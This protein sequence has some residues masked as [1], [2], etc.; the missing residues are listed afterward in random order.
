MTRRATLFAFMCGCGLAVGGCA[1]LNHKP[2]ADAAATAPSATSANP[3]PAATTANPAINADTATPIPD[4]DDTSPLIQWED[5]TIAP[6][7]I[8]YANLW[9]YLGK[10]FSLSAAGGD[11]RVQGELNWFAGHGTYLQRT[12]NR[13][14]PYLY[15]IVQQVQARKIPLD[16]ALLPVVE[17]AF[18]PFAYSNG[19]AAGLWQFIPGT[20]R[21]WD[22]KQDWW[23]DGRRDIVASTNAALDYLQ[24]LHNQFNN[25][26]LLALA[27]YNSGGGTVSRAIQRNLRRGLPTDF[28]HLDLPAETRAYVPRLLAICQLIATSGH[29][30]VDLPAIPNI[31]YLAVVD[32]GGQ[33]DLATAAK[34]A[35][36]T[37]EQ[38]YLL[39][40][41][42][43][44]WATDPQG[45]YSLLVP[46]DK[47]NAFTTALASLPPHDRVQWATHSVQSGDTI[48]EI[49]R[50]YHTTVAVLREL[51][52]IHGNL[53]REHQM[54]LIPVARKTMADITMVAEARVAR[55]RRYT[56]DRY[57]SHGRIVHH[58]RQGES[59]WSIARRYDVKV[60]ELIQWN[61]LGRHQVLRVGQKLTIRSRRARALDTAS[62]T[63]PGAQDSQRTV[64]YT[65]HEGDSLFSISSRFRV[66]VANIADWNGIDKHDYIHA[67]EHLKLYVDVT[68]QSTSS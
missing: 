32:A 18:D 11:G 66:S 36:I 55:R 43:N 57:E 65:V 34:L 6:A 12:A 14:R 54:L 5:I 40:P 46:L 58:V 52:G 39:N 4:L 20:G 47:K 56:H 16:I 25:D 67:G 61:M 13:A 21:R 51:N 59:L 31:T 3:P 35:G 24:Y 37:N 64:Y 22:L 33:I 48:G 68:D 38:M 2:P 63:G 53:I 19:R 8:K 41:G 15:Y 49:A 29:Y 50:H 62:A 27:A 60:A 42:F 10:N 44:R 26:W 9:D 17:S 7:E 23:Y 28:W 45:P 1:T 30:G